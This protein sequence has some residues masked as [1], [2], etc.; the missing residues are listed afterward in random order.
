MTDA[1]AGMC[2]L[3]VFAPGWLPGARHRTIVVDM[4]PF[5]ARGSNGTRGG[6]RVMAGAQGPAASPAGSMSRRATGYAVAVLG[7]LL[8]GRLSDVI[9]SGKPG[10]V[11]FTVALF[12]LPVLYAFRRT[13]PWLDR[14][15]WPVLAVQAVLTWVPFAIFGAGWQEGIGGLLAGLVLLMVPG[16][17]SWLLAGG[18]LAAEVTVRAAGTGLPL[19]QTWMSVSWVVTYY[20]DDALVFFGMVRLAQIVG[21]VEQARGQATDLAVARERLQAAGSLQAAVGQRL[22]DVAAMI[23]AARQALSRD[24]TSARAQVAAAGVTAR[25]AVAQARSVITAQGEARPEPV[26]PRSAS[27]VIGARLAWAVLVTVLLMFAVENI[28]WIVYS[29][30]GT[31]LTALA[32]GDVLLTVGL[33][34]HHSG[35]VRRGRKPRAWP[36]TLALQAALVYA[37]LLPFVWAYVGA[38]APFLAGSVLLLVPG[39]WRW[40]G[41]AAVVASFAVLYSVL[42]VR[43]NIIPDGKQIPSALFYAAVT[44]GVGLMVY[45]LSRLAGLARE[46][47][48]LRDRLARMAAVRERLRVARDVH[49]LLGLGLSAIALKSD[50]IAA[51]I[52]RDDSRA[53][54]EIEEMSR[55]CATV[56][57]DAR[58]VT[59]DGRRLSLVAELAAAEQ[60]LAS[61]GIEV[62]ADTCGE[63]LPAAADDVLAP[64]LREAVTNILRHAAATACLIELTAGPTLRL[65]VSNDGARRAATEE[66]TRAG[67]KGLGLANLEGRVRAAGGRLTIRQADGRFGPTAELPLGTR[68]PEQPGLEDVRQPALSG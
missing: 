6:S 27:A 38:L 55:I 45:G 42:G 59:G 8:A 36:L 54:A 17:V 48:G 9:S 68:E 64:V 39:R 4:I 13:R 60:I 65:H 2:I 31:R 7:L 34:L 28:A 62:R 30:Y 19:P 24:A 29:Q 14:H 21:E 10:E 15:R 40:A 37:F 22:A 61:A 3:H 56:R 25:D 49:D 44:A 1:F 67:G 32:I 11:L 26:A 63:P 52:G 53:A 35:A 18:L 5:A 57:A 33:Q 12:V 50:L 23:A 41:Y 16:R 46:L 20:V 47:E 58:L 66:P 43:G 51:L